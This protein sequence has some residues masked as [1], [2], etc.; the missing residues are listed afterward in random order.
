MLYQLLFLIVV[1][2]I[3]KYARKDLRN[4]TLYA[5]NLVLSEGMENFGEIEPLES[6]GMKKNLGKIK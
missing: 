1:Y 6:K 5:G 2:V 3:V 4:E